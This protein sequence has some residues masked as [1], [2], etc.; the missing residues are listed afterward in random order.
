MGGDAESLWLVAA[1][2][3][4]L[5]LELGLGVRVEKGLGWS[6]RGRMDGVL[7][8]KD[9]AGVVYAAVVVNNDKVEG[10]FRGRRGF[11]IHVAGK[12]QLQGEGMMA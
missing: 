6:Y 2:G 12:A 1:G 11:E 8:V 3:R 4:W 10:D 9:E 7:F 5:G